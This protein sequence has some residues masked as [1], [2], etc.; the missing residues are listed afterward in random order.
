MQEPEQFEKEI[1][2]ELRQED[3]KENIG[4]E[5]GEKNAGESEPRRTES[6][7]ESI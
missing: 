6:E 4:C 7:K 5:S 1:E 3:E 2:S